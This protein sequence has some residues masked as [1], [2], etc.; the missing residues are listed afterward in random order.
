VGTD[1][2]LA[3]LAAAIESLELPGDSM[4]STPD[5]QPLAILTPEEEITL[6]RVAFGQ[7][8]VRAMRAADLKRLRTLRLIEDGKDG[9]QVKASGRK[10]FNLLPRVATLDRG[11]AGDD[12]LT[13]M[14]RMLKDARR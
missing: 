12:L 9:P 14:N 2:L 10:H 1:F 4:A 3:R 13:S 11:F 7:S 8:E 5:T 6:R